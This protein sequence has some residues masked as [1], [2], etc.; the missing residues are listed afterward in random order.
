MDTNIGNE[1]WFQKEAWK[2]LHRDH[3]G[4]WDYSD[5]SLLYS[6]ESLNA[7]R[8]MQEDGTEYA[9]NVTAVEHDV[10]KRVARDLVA[11][12][13]DRFAYM[14]LGPGTEHKEQ[15]FFEAMQ[16]AHKQFVKNK[17]DRPLYSNILQ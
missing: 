8:Q 7:Y 14:D 12:L 13:P 10:L 16:I 15:Y 5:S 11:D 6:P 4:S 17:G 9:N 3:D 2:A 1:A